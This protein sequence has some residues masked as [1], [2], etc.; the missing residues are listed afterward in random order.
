MSRTQP[1]WMH[2][3]DHDSKPFILLLFFFHNPLQAKNVKNSDTPFRRAAPLPGSHRSHIGPPVNKKHKRLILIKSKSLTESVPLIRPAFQPAIPR[4]E[5]NSNPREMGRVSVFFTLQNS[6]SDPKFRSWP[7]DLPRLAY[8]FLQPDRQR[9]L[10]QPLGYTRLASPPKPTLTGT[11]HLSH[12]R[13]AKAIPRGPS[14]FL[15]GP[16]PPFLR[17]T[18]DAPAEVVSGWQPLQPLARYAPG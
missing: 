9:H 15:T 4:E 16:P 14:A 18:P 5:H 11:M 13:P 12:C 7:S 10:L 2:F 6:L 17:R 3:S 1:K 8:S